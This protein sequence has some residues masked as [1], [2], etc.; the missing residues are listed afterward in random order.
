MKYKNTTAGTFISR[1]NRFIA[2]VDVG[3]EIKVCHVK[4]TGRCRELLTPN[5]KVIL[6]RSDAPARKTEYD[7]IAVYKGDML[8]NIDSQA[9]NKVF[10]EWTKR[11]TFF[12]NVTLI[13]PEFTYGKSRFDFYIEAD[14]KKILAEIKG[15]TL[16][17]GGAVLFPD[18]PTER[19]VKHVKE[20]IKAKAEGFDSYLFF[21]IQMRNCRYFTPNRMTHPEF[22][23]ALLEAKKQ[24]VEIFA[25][26][27]EVDE[28]SLEIYDFVP[29]ILDVQ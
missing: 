10:G 23:D 19:G 15:V 4:N 13:K 28:A 17:D 1:P 20:L 22:A 8:I 26:N 5:A 24:G 25:L 27:C 7:L 14:G 2:N 16:E 3:G 12:K 11:V 18:A 29:V 9:P 6:E 21:V